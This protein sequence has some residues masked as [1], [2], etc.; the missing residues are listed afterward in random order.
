VAILPAPGDG[1]YLVL[2]DAGQV[3]ADGD[4]GP[5]A[6]LAARFHHLKLPS[7]STAVGMAL[8]TSG[9][10]VLDSDGDVQ[11]LPGLSVTSVLPPGDG[12]PLAIVA[13]PDTK[14]YWVLSSSGVVV[15]RGEAHAEGDLQAAAG[16]PGAIAGP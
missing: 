2:D 7:G 3:F 4:L 1:G 9:I 6:K 13:T 12:V 8:D 16:S 14:G 5:L 10:V 15:A 11:S